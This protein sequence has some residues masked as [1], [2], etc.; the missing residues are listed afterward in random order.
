MV[1]SAPAFMRIRAGT[2]QTGTVAE[3]LNLQGWQVVDELN[4]LFAGQAVSGFVAP[5]RLVTRENADADGGSRFVYDPQ[6]GYR[7]VYLRIWKPR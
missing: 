7:D 1:G 6:N 2:Y 4:R 3:P 5:V